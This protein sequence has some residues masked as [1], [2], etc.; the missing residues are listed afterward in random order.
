MAFWLAYAEAADQ[1]QSNLTIVVGAAAI[2]IVVCGLAFV[3][4]LIAW[5]RRHRHSD[6]ILAFAILWGLLSAASAVST[7]MTQ[8]NWSKERMIRIE[9]GY[10]DPQ[11]TSD[12]PTLPWAAWAGLAC[13]YIGLLGWAF[14][15]EV[16]RAQRTPRD[17]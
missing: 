17:T 10:D 9:S 5:S 6:T 13:A 8:F 7:S 14:R 11:D 16:P 2:V 15:S 12:A 1:S 3:P 4:V